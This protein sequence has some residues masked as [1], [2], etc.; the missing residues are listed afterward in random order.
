MATTLTWILY[1]IVI[2][3]LPILYLSLGFSRATKQLPFGRLPGYCSD[4][5]KVSEQAWARAQKISGPRYI[6]LGLLSAALSILFSL[7][8]SSPTSIQLAICAL[9]LCAAQFT[10]QTFVIASIEVSLR[11][12]IA[13]A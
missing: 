13:H 3:I 10:V 2:L 4:L 1:F 7:V 6:I 11:S 9:I 12:F 5:S 8:L